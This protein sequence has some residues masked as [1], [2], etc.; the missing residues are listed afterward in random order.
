MSDLIID[1]KKKNAALTSGNKQYIAQL[2]KIRCI[3]RLPMIIMPNN[4]RLMH[5]TPSNSKDK[6]VFNGDQDSYSIDFFYKQNVNIVSVNIKA[7]TAEINKLSK[8]SGV[9]ITN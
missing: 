3:K 6:I 2:N 9:P 8:L 4:R 5:V 7:P 1:S